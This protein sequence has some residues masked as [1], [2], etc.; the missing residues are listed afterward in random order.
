MLKLWRKVLC[1]DWD[2]HSIRVVVARVGSGQV[3]LED[4]HAHRI[5]PEVDPDQPESLGAFIRQALRGRRIGLKRVVV[6]IPRDRAVMNHLTLPPTPPL[7]V[8]AAVRFQAFKELPFPLDEAVIDFVVKKR[9]ERGWVTG[10]L[11]AAVT[12]EVLGQV[13]AVC[14]AAGLQPVRIGLRPYANLLGVRYLSGLGDKHVLFVDVGPTL[15]EIDVMDCGTLAFARAANVT[16][17][18]LSAAGDT[19]SGETPAPQLAAP[20]MTAPEN[21]VA[22]LT[23][24]ITRTV[25]AYRAS[26]PEAVIDAIVI[27]GSTGVEARL[28]EAVERRFGLP[29]VLFDPTPALGVSPQEAEKLRSFS[30]V[31]GLAWGMSLPGAFELDFLNPKRPVSRQEILKKRLRTVGVAVGVVVAVALATDLSLYWR[32]YGEYE[33]LQERAGQLAGELKR[34]YEIQNLVDEV[35]EWSFEAVWP[36]HLL[37]LTENAVEPGKNML[38]QQISLDAR[39]ASIGLKKVLASHWDVPA[40]FV[41]RL[42]EL[43]DEKGQRLYQATEG[44]WRPLKGR[45]GEF[46]GVV[47]VQVELRDLKRYLEQREERARERQRRLRGL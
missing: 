28:R 42:N 9:D 20:E 34:Y 5:P 33:R 35:A 7:E 30:A 29:T 37:R 27:A 11:L 13:Q 1:L 17:P 22:E 23:V 21:A 32:R 43:R 26:E 2:R 24:E 36:E 38:V 8:A 25:Q 39:T 19:A 16:V 47:E 4:A 18:I 3:E 6:H 44:V 46:T 12:R 41:N 40:A 31:L 10:V 14:Q 45:A 15:T